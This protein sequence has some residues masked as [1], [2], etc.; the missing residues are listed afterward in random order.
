MAAAMRRQASQLLPRRLRAHF[1][2]FSGWCRCVAGAQTGPQVQPAKTAARRQDARDEG[3]SQ[4]AAELRS[5]KQK[6]R[7]CEE[8]L[9]S[10]R[11]FRC[12]IDDHSRG[13]FVPEVRPFGAGSPL[14]QFLG[15]A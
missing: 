8:R 7:D 13:H 3:V 14:G 9:G 11:N 6:I 4:E 12:E 1:S 10:G 5:K 2:I 15:Q